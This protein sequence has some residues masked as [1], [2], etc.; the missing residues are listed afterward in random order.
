MTWP[1]GDSV[2]AF[3]VRDRV[4][5]MRDR[6]DVFGLEDGED[7]VE[8]FV[9]AGAFVQGGAAHVAEDAL[10]GDAGEVAA[11]LAHLAVDVVVH[12]FERALGFAARE[13]PPRAVVDGEGALR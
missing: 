11:D 13:V 1:A 12:R 2:S 4:Q 10:D 6:R 8:A 5:S 9:D 3:D 7:F